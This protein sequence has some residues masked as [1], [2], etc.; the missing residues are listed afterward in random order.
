MKLN[1]KVTLSLNKY[2]ETVPVW[3]SSNTSVCTLQVADG[4]QTAVATAVGLGNAIVDVR[5]NSDLG[6]GVRE[7]HVQFEV[8]VDGQE[9]FVDK[10]EK[11]ED[12]KEVEET[13][14]S[15]WGSEKFAREAVE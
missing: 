9:S 14:T 8:S 6:S 13:K 5:L 10:T 1:E 3:T 15:Y 11:V 2:S 12:T 4:G 7:H